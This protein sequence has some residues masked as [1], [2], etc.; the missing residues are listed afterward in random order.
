[1]EP[2]LHRALE[3]AATRFGGRDALLAGEDR[4]SFEALDGWAN[5]FG[6]HLAQRGVGRGDRVAVMMTNRMEFV[7]AVNAISRLGAAAVLLSPAWKA[8]EVGHAL[9]LTGARHA[10]AD[11][12]GA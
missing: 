10:V 4:W 12:P 3:R 6:R 2:L 7:V 11:D 9:E 5:A 8:V 1:M